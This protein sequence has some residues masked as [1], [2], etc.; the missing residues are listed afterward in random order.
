MN[1]VSRFGRLLLAAGMLATAAAAHAQAPPKVGDRL[2]MPE[3]LLLDG[4]RLSAADFAGKPLVIEYWASWCPYCA[5]QNPHLQKL[6]EAARDKG[7]R[8][9]TVSI[10]KDEQAARDYIAKHGY[11]FGVAMDSEA[12]RAVFGKRRVVPEVFV[13]DASGK[14]VEDIPGEMFEEDMLE[15]LRHAPPRS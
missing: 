2:V 15:L 13:L 1:A 6:T 11:T 3:V 9:L 7:L 8:I 4:T 5:R 14:L 10:D 12:L